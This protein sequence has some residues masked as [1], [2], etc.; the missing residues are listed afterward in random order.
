[1]K[2]NLRKKLGILDTEEGGDL[3]SGFGRGREKRVN[4]K[5]RK[6]GEGGIALRWGFCG[7]SR[8]EG[9]EHRRTDQK[10]KG[11][12]ELFD[13]KKREKRRLETSIDSI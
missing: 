2:S 5:K 6:R 1:V 13:G 8:G 3:N 7:S 9:V 12:E 4:G 10:I 11:R